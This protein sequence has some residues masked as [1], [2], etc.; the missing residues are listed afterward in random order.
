MA[1]KN[2]KNIIRFT[3]PFIAEC[4]KEERHNP[5]QNADIRFPPINSIIVTFPTSRTRGRSSHRSPATPA[6]TATTPGGRAAL[7]PGYTTSAPGA[8][9][10]IWTCR[11]QRSRCSF[12]PNIPPENNIRNQGYQIDQTQDSPR[13]YESG[14]EDLFPGHRRLLLT[15]FGQCPS[16]FFL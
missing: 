9:G 13:R 7:V 2:A 3:L 4:V 8:R 5:Q 1:V 15:R 6:H 16:F 14:L 10:Y 11:L 12:M